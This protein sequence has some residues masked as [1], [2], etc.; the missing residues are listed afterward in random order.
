MLGRTSMTGN[1]YSAATSFSSETYQTIIRTRNI[2]STALLWPSLRASVASRQFCTTPKPTMSSLRQDRSSVATVAVAQ[3]TSVGCQETNFAACRRLAMEAKDLGC[4]MLFLPE[5]CSFI[6]L[7]QREAG[8]A[9]SPYL[10]SDATPYLPRQMLG[11]KPDLPFLQTVA[12]GQPLDGSAMARFRDLARSTNIWLS[13]GGFQETGP[14]SEH[15]YNTHVVLDGQGQI[16]ASYRKASISIAEA[17]VTQTACFA[18]LPPNLS[19][20]E[21]GFMGC[22]QMLAGA[23]LQRGGPQWASAHGGQEHSSRHRGV[24]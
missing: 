5:C 23:S 20:T 12:A 16:V 10:L 14:D 17:H 13:L 19:R 1:V 4:C 11:C 22:Q 9:T 21:M 7:N 3:M 2:R 15:I 6:G 24:Q 18:L 8:N